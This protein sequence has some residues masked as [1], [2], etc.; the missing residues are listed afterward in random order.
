MWFTG[1]TRNTSQIYYATSADGLS[2]KR[3]AV[4][5]VLEARSPWEKVAVMCPCVILDDKTEKFRLYYSAGEQFEPDA[6]GLASSSDGVHWERELQ[7]PVFSASPLHTWEQAKVTA[8]D[9]HR[10]DGWFY[11]FYIGF[12]DQNHAAIGVARSRDGV[13]NWQRHPRNPILSPPGIKGTLA[14]DRDAIYKPAALLQ[15]SGWLLWF[16]G[17]RNYREQI[18]L[19]RHPGIDLGFGDGF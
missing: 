1:Q 10:V 6:I 5:P 17:R 14:W 18:G 13:S 15:D 11:M 7:N 8:C 16:N 12:S 4:A 9:V 3:I 19:A 2:W